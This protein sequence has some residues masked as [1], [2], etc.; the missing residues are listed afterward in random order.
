MRKVGLVLGILVLVV[1][2]A[3]LIFWATFD[4][5]RYRG[6]IQSEL[7]D[8]LNRQVSLGDMH[9]GLFPPSFQVK[10][11]SIADDPAFADPKPFVQADQFSV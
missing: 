2:V 8:R 9:L 7:Q 4:V 11:V 5:N 6:R 1:V 10:S 3:V